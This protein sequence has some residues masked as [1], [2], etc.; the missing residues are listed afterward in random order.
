MYPV[1]VHPRFEMLSC[2]FAALLSLSLSGGFALLQFK[3]IAIEKRM[4]LSCFI[5]SIARSPISF[6]EKPHGLPF[7]SNVLR[8]GL[9]P[10]AN[11]DAA[12]SPIILGAEY[13]YDTSLKFND[14][15]ICRFRSFWRCVT[16]S[17]I[18]WKPD[19][20]TLLMMSCLLRKLLLLLAN[21]PLNF[22]HDPHTD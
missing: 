3:S 20:N 16:S 18:R 8:A 22:Q 17:E 1:Y 4:H 14:S 2:F 6:F 5:V 11:P 13:I 7:S 15:I 21:F 19:S 12:T 10:A 9:H